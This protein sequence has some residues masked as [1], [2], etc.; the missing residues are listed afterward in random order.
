MP[1]VIV[2]IHP[3][4]VDNEP[5]RPGILVAV[6]LSVLFVCTG[7]VCRSPMAELLFRAWCAPDADVV[8]SSAG[9]YALTGRG[10]DGPSLS[11]L[12]GL[13]IDGSA[14]RA[15][16]FEPGHATGADLVLTA[17]TEQRD[18]VIT[19]APSAF[20][21]V[22]TLREFA[23]LVPPGTAGADPAL[24]VAGC[25]A[26]RGTVPPVRP[27]ADD[28]GDPYGGTTA[29]ARRV[30]AEIGDAVRVV[31]AALGCAARPQ[32]SPAERPA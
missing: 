12:R 26:R 10:M 18:L 22:F 20:R 27:G 4:A 32:P 9:T 5:V 30:A 16:Q 1:A 31:T 8:A 7:N 19:A 13:G 3:H 23:R 15:R 24:T 11:A 28:I 25:A 2:K 17:T 14:H 21:R 29:Q 6:S